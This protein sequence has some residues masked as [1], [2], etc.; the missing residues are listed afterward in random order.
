LLSIFVTRGAG[1]WP[2]WQLVGAIIGVDVSAATGCGSVL[3]CPQ[4]LAS[5]FTAFGWLTGAPNR[6]Q[7]TAPHGGWT[8]IVTIIRVW[9]YSFGVVV[10]MALVYF[11]LNSIPWLRDLGRRERAKKNNHWED[12]RVSLHCYFRQLI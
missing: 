5:F 10:V 8:D 4:I 12:F 3:T 6:N 7:I 11:I 2:S 1:R 9:G